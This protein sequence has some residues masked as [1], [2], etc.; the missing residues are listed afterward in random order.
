MVKNTVLM[1][2][3]TG[4]M[5]EDPSL[6]ANYT[7]LMANDTGLIAKYICFMAKYIGLM[8][9]DTGLMAKDTCLIAE[10]LHGASIYI[11]K[12]I[13]ALVWRILYLYSQMKHI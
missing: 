6:T 2:I 3:D 12:L 13:S 8:A 11:R 5:A 9:E 10:L 7:G 4:F 1:D